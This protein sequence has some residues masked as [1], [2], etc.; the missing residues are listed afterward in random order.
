MHEK[1][2]PTAKR[3]NAMVKFSWM[4]E[5]E[6]EDEDDEV[7]ELSWAL[8]EAHPCA[9]PLPTLSLSAAGVVNVSFWRILEGLEALYTHELTPLA[10]D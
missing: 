7:T 1:T 3:T 5:V 8:I 2:M 9:L 4:D 10:F 6:D